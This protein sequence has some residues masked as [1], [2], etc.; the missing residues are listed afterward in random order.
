VGDT[1]LIQ[2]APYKA[3]NVNTLCFTCYLYKVVPHWSGERWS[4]IIL[5]PAASGQLAQR[6]IEGKMLQQL[7]V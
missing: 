5:S 2:A 7:Y 1:V 4:C 3:R 6:I